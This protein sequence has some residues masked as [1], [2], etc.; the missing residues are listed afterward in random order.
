MPTTPACRSPR[1]STAS[2]TRPRT[3][4]EAVFSWNARNFMA[5]GRRARRRCAPIPGRV[6]ALGRRR[7]RRSRGRKAPSPRRS[8]DAEAKVNHAW[9]RGGWCDALTMAWKDVAEGA[10]FER[11]PVTEGRP[12]PGA[13]LFVPFTPRA[14]RLEDDRPAA[15]LVRG[16]EPTCAS[17][18]DPRGRR[19]RRASVATAPGT[20]GASRAST[21]CRSTGG[22]ATTRCARRPQRFS[23]CFYDTTLPPEVVEAVAANLTILK[24]PTVLRQADGRLWGWEGCGDNCGLLPRL[25]HARLELRPGH[26]APVPG[27]RAHAARDGVR[28]RRRTTAGTRPSAPRCRSGPSTTTSTPPPTA[29]SAAS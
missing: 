11:P 28:R 18:D 4:V 22:R 9:F 13:T 1:S 25:L 21:R 20:R 14:R 24:S 19:A 6:H 23:D 12:A 27:A 5:V 17:A 7:A 2:R 29:S 8:D 3:P 10:C 15:R 26:A 16:R